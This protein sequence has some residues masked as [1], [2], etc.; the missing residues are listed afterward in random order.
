MIGFG[1]RASKTTKSPTAAEEAALAVLGCCCPPL[2]F[3]LKIS[4]F[5]AKKS[6]LAFEPYLETFHGLNAS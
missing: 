2:A 6:I 5:T 1:G 3:S 4:Y